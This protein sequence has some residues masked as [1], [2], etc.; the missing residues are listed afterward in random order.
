MAAVEIVVRD[1]RARAQVPA[2]RRLLIRLARMTGRKGAGVTLL[3][4][5]DAAVRRLNS[6]FRGVDAVTDVLSFRAEGDLEPSRPHLGEIAISVPQAA[7][8]AKRAGW[9]LKSEMALLLTHGFLHLLGHDHETDGGTMRRLEEDL[10]SRAAGVTLARRGL[11]WGEDRPPARRGRRTGA[12]R[13][14]HD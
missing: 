2:C 5:S 10:L 11:P 12:R 9:S 4:A 1:L 7:R 13:S 3:L 6:R 14:T 8:Q